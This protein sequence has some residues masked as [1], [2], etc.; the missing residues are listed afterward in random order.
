MNG[1]HT[2]KKWFMQKKTVRVNTQKM[3]AAVKKKQEKRKKI[4]SNS[5]KN[6]PYNKETLTLTAM[7]DFVVNV[8][9]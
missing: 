7:Q 3:P 5:N 9:L 1:V 8:T 6:Q 4:S 2:A